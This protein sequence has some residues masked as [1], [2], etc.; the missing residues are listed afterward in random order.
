ML[1]KTSE[2]K[3]PCSQDQEL[4]LEVAELEMRIRYGKL[5]LIATL[6]FIIFGVLIFVFFPFLKNGLMTFFYLHGVAIFS[7]L[8]LLPIIKKLHLPLSSFGLN[9]INWKR[10]VLVGSL[11]SCAFVSLFII[12]YLIFYKHHH[13]F[14]ELG[15]DLFKYHAHPYLFLLYITVGW[16]FYVWLLYGVKLNAIKYFLNDTRGLWSALIN[17]IFQSAVFFIASEEFGITFFFETFLCG[18][19]YLSTSPSIIGFM[20]FTQVWNLTVTLYL[21]FPLFDPSMY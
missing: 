11:Y 8:I 14:Y 7:V 13:S 4:G 6:I 18:L 2:G 9:N 5:F 10:G 17:A 21:V 1:T 19:I 16:A 15:Q 12:R 3:I 20:L